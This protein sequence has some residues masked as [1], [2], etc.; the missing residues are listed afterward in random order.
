MRP[1]TESG[2]D[3]VRNISNKLQL[4]FGIYKQARAALTS[5]YPLSVVI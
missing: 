2:D 5:N 4:G 3:F 1:K